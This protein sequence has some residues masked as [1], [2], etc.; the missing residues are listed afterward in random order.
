MNTKHYKFYLFVFLFVNYTNQVKSQNQYV[1]WT[2]GLKGGN[3]Y[4]DPFIF[5]FTP[6]AGPGSQIKY[7]S[8]AN[9]EY[10]YKNIRIAIEAITPK[11]MYQVGSNLPLKWSD[12][13]V[14]QYMKGKN[15]DYVEMRFARAIAGKK[16][17]VFYVGAQ[18]DLYKFENMNTYG[19]YPRGAYYSTGSL[20]GESYVD[21]FITTTRGLSASST[22]KAGKGAFFRLSYLHN[23]MSNKSYNQKGRNNQFELFY[24]KTFKTKGKGNVGFNLGLVAQ[25]TVIDAFNMDQYI[26]T[27]SGTKAAPEIRYKNLSFVANINIPFKFW[28]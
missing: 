1:A 2:I 23:W 4:Y 11:F 17:L 21:K 10:N 15:T 18:F 26:T 22:V 27:N 19:A 25:N 8:D 20:E 13:K 7:T 12:F 16:A 9:D 3:M 14:N 24:Y 28:D 5:R 6:T